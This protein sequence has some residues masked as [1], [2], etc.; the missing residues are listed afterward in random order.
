[1]RDPQPRVQRGQDEDE[2]ERVRRDDEEPDDSQRQQGGR[3]ACELV[4]GRHVPAPCQPLARHEP[5]AKSD[6]SRHGKRQDRPVVARGCLRRNG[7]RDARRP[8]AEQREKLEHRA[9]EE[10]EPQAGSIAA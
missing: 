8:S 5:A 2:R 3:R 4:R 9:G 7:P 1:M 10:P 6:E